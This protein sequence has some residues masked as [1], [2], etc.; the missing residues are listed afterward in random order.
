MSVE[1]TRLFAILAE[2]DDV[3]TDLFIDSVYLGFST[4]KMSEHYSISR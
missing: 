1:S 2:Y 4:H 3:F